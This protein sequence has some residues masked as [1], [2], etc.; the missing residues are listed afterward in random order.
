MIEVTKEYK[1]NIYAL[2][3]DRKMTA[4]IRFTMDG[5]TTNYGE[6][7]I[8]DI[9]ILEEMDTLSTSIPS[10]EVK[11]TLD[12]TGGEFSFLTLSNIQEIIAKRPKIEVEIGLELDDLTVEYIP[13]GTYYL[14][15][16][17]NSIGAMTITLIG[18][19]SFDMLSQ[20]SYNRNV[21]SNLYDLAVDILT[22]AG[23]T[24]YKIDS[25]LLDISTTGFPDRIDSRKA[26]QHIGVASLSAV[27]QDRYG[28]IVIEPFK[29]LGQ[30]NNFLTFCGQPLLYTS[31]TTYPRVDKGFDMK[32]ISYE[33]IYK[34]PEIKLDK[35]IYEVVVL[36]YPE[37]TEHVYINTS[38]KGKNGSSFKV[39]NPLINTEERARKVAER[40]IRESNINA[41]YK[42]IWRQN[43]ILECG[44]MIL[45]QDNF[46]AKKQTRITRNEFE[47]RGYLR[48]NTESRGGI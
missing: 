44:D 36:V 15:E 2:T 48:G 27:Y 26:L 7:Y 24:E 39:D 31:A 32:N 47:F 18:R 38:I 12:N 8:V 45:V 37:K 40:I 9:N 14:I 21:T 11:I 35:S 1:D 28:K 13:M 42:T 5:V 22:E 3:K 25:S 29:G 23:I 17:K 16:W 19:D 43:P 10:N 6:T 20:I 4:R 30:S 33:N 34:E 41:I 46:D